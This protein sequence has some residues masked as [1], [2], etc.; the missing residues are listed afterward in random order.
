M[1]KQLSDGE[2]RYLLASKRV[3]RLGCIFDDGPYVVPV[4]YLF[5]DNQI[6]VH[7]RLGRKIK[8]LRANPRA[9]LQVD[10]ILDEYQWRS[11]IAYGEYHE[12]T[13]SEPRSRALAELLKRFPHLTPVESI[14]DDDST[15]VVFCIRVKQLT[16]IGEGSLPP[17]AM[18]GLQ[19]G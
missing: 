15:L 12:L 2:I 10:E 11:A 13:D 19:R 18:P 3:G 9:C 16:G 7:S 8:A 14:P 5:R 4:S 1:L 6:Y 17:I